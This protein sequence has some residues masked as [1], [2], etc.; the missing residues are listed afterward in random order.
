MANPVSSFAHRYIHT[1]SRDNPTHARVDL[2]SAS[3]RDVRA[4]MGSKEIL[5]VAVLVAIFASRASSA[6]LLVAGSEVAV[7]LASHLAFW[8]ES[9]SSSSRDDVKM[10][11][12]FL[13]LNSLPRGRV[14]PSGPSKRTNN[15]IS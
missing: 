10:E 1:I 8:R 13:L 2:V 14:P 5:V 4:V 15:L 7:E 12:K 9:G 11:D 6:R 3:S